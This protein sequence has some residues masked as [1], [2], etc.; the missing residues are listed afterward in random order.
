MLIRKNIS[1]KNMISQILDED[2]IKV[3]MFTCLGWFTE[4]V[5]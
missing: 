5:K 2:K 1:H 4:K 3:F